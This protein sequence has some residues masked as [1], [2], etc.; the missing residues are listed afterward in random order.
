MRLITLTAIFLILSCYCCSQSE[1]IYFGAL[2][3]DKSIILEDQYTF[4]KNQDS[5]GKSEYGMNYENYYKYIDNIVKSYVSNYNEIIYEYTLKFHV[6]EMDKLTNIKIGDKF[7]VA[8]ESGVYNSEVI[9]YRVDLEDMI[10]SGI[11]FYSLLNKVSDDEQKIVLVSTSNTI[12]K[13]FWEEI[14]DKTTVNNIKKTLLSKVKHIKVTEGEDAGKKIS[15]IKDDE[16]TILKGSFT[17]KDAE[18]YL[19]SWCKRIS[20]DSYACVTYV[21]DENGKIIKTVFKLREKE[22]YFTKASAICDINGDGICEIIT[23]EGYYEGHGW[24]L[25]KFDGEELNLV[26]SG[27]YFG[28]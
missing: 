19:V 9:G 7:Y 3:E 23:E 16:L 15:S 21:M 10:G 13:M 28:V 1:T 8:S 18:E 22:F 26:T 25:W 11:V 27:F 2:L 17:L 6:Q 4:Q 12:S 14:S 20:F 24:G 5:W